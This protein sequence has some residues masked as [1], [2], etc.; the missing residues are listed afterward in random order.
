M[1]QP[2]D[3]PIGSATDDDIQSDSGVS[4]SSNDSSDVFSLSRGSDLPIVVSGD[5]SDRITQLVEEFSD[6][7][8]EVGLQAADVPPMP[9]VLKD[10]EMPKPIPPRRLSPAMHAVVRSEIA[11]WLEAGIIKASSSPCSAPLVM[12]KKKDG[13]YQVCV[14]YRS[15]NACTVDMKYPMQ[16]PKVIL[17][18][19]AG[20]KVFGT[21]DL[22]S[23]FHQIPLDDSSGPLTAFATPDGLYEST[24]VQFGLKNG[25]PFFQQTVNQ[26]LNGL[27]GTA[28]EVFIDDIIV[29]GHDMDDFLQHLRAVFARLK[30]YG[31]HLKGTKCRL[32]LGEVE[33]LGHIV[34]GDGIALSSARKQGLLQVA[35]PRSTA[36][37]RSFMG[38]ANYFRSFIPNFA[39]ISKP[40]HVL[41]SNKVKFVWSDTE[42]AAFVALK[43]AIAE[44]PLLHHLDYSKPIILR[45]DA[46]TAGVGGMLLQ[47]VAGMERPVSF[48]SKAFTPA[49]SKWSTIE[50][51]AFAIYYCVTSL[52]HFLLGHPF[53]VETDHKNLLYLERATAPKIV[54]WRLRL[55]EFNFQLV[56]I[57]GKSNVVADALSRCFS[58]AGAPACDSALPAEVPTVLA[59]PVGAV[60]HLDDIS[61][62]H[63]AL[64][65]HHGIHRTEAL[66]RGAGKSWDSMRDEVAAFIQSCPTCQ[67]VRLGQGS[68]AAALSTTVASEPFD[69]VAVDTVGPLPIDS[70]GNRYVIAVIDCFTRFVELRATASPTAQAAVTVLLD[71]FARYGAPRALRS[72]QGSQFTARLVEQFLK[73]VGTA[74][75]LTFA[76]HPE[77]NGIVERANAELGRHLRALVLDRRMA[78]T[79]SAALPLVQRIMNAAPH[80]G[81]GTAPVRLLF[82]DAIT[83]DRHLLVDS[84]DF[85]GKSSTVE[86]YIQ[87]LQVSQATLVAASQ[88]HQEKVVARRLK[89]SP[90]TPTTFQVGD[91]VLVSY[92]NRPPSKLAPRWRGPMVIVEQI[93]SNSYS[94]QD[95]TTCG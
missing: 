85:E 91:Y 32:G 39:L 11:E 89:D 75:Q 27:I 53:V 74:H 5:D 19:M 37:L 41:C 67:K 15:L 45:T 55:Q 54:R 72:D 4:A 73:E 6:V 18:R 56:H 34:N 65:G 20:Q 63:N 49:E 1:A 62:V 60:S 17:E 58:V 93:G 43:D 31:F 28:C 50:Q 88:Q 40:L 36:Q 79:W 94:C 35:A 51:E 92:P 59:A 64:L 13:S 46:S 9:I 52:Q 90:A 33:Y 14:D 84:K 44:A 71:V 86:D 77:A 10:G 70:N 95:L 61:A 3:K 48:V 24:R 29:Y 76:Y 69:V 16:N 21:L 47:K 80:A 2:G 42:Q 26:V 87:Q 12:V 68:M 7:F 66:L 81:T 83:P 38:M 82:G 23:G 25:P 78:S 30:Q 22:R 8:N 57:A